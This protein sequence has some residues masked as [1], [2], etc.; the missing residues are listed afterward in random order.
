[1]RRYELKEHTNNGDAVWFN[2]QNNREFIL[3]AT[4]SGFTI[5]EMSDVEFT[6]CDAVTV[7]MTLPFGVKAFELS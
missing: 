6:A 4:R 7:A 2:A 1:M 3:T 5:K